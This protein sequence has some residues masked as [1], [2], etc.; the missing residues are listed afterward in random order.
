MKFVFCFL[1]ILS[2]CKDLAALNTKDCIVV[3]GPREFKES[4]LVKL[5][6]EAPA[7]M[8]R[9]GSARLLFD[10]LR[11]EHVIKGTSESEVSMK[12]RLLNY[13]TFIKKFP[14]SELGL[15]KLDD[16]R[17]VKKGPCFQTE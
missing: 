3:I 8:T 11:A 12:D 14:D 5:K 13:E 7:T 16:I 1:L 6:A 15:R 2:S 17:T 4:D 10:L 9:N